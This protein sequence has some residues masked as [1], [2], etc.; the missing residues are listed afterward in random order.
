MSEFRQVWHGSTDLGYMLGVITGWHVGC[1]N[2]RESVAAVAHCENKG[3]VGRRLHYFPD[4]DDPV[5]A[6][7]ITDEGLAQMSKWGRNTKDAEQMRLWYRNKAA[8]ISKASQDATISEA[9]SP[10]EQS[11][12]T[13]S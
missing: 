10:P 3:W 9:S 13:A 1:Q 11:L 8:E 5:P 4:G 12:P 7:E 6:F 2:H